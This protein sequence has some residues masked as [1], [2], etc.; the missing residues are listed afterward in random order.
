MNLEMETIGAVVIVLMPG[1]TF[2]AAA[3]D[4]FNH[5]IAPIIHESTHVVFDL[6]NIRF[7]DSMGCGALLKCHK[8][9]KEKEGK[10]GLC[11]AQK[12]VRAIFDLMGFPEL[13]DVYK[14]REDALKAYG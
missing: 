13:F 1:E 14:T 9:L 3:V 8:K 11:C 4:N 5:A 10:M 2:E 7:L 12:P 6:S